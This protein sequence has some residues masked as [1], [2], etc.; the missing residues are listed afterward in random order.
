[1]DLLFHRIQ[2]GGFA[3]LH[4]PL[5]TALQVSLQIAQ[6]PPRLAQMSREPLELSFVQILIKGHHQGT[7]LAEDFLLGA[8]GFH[9]FQARLSQRPEL[10]A[11]N[12]QQLGM[13]RG[14]QRSHEM[15]GSVLQ[16]LKGLLAIVALVKDQGDVIAGFGQ[17]PVMGREF[18]GDGA[19]LGAVVDIAGVNLVEQ[20]DVE[21]GADQQAET[22]LAQIAAL[23]LI[24]PALRQF[25]RGADIDVGEEIGAVVDQGAEIQLKPLDE[26]LG[27]LFFAFED[28]IGGDQIHMVPEALGRQRGR[29]GGQQTSQDRLAVPVSKVHFAGGG[30]RTIDGSQEQ[31]LPEG[32]ALVA[33]GRKDGI[34][35]LDEIQSLRN[36]EKSGGISE[37]GDLGFE[38]LGRLLRPLGG[39]DEVVDF[40]EVGGRFWACR[41]RADNSGRSNRCG[42]R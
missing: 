25:G 37:S 13:L 31:V 26:A 5:P 12:G 24:M 40:A 14:D 33:F 36:V 42:R 23:L 21:I 34:E 16:R 38:G 10:F 29:I 18:F 4:L 8:I 28:V 19:E 35:Q 6:F 32:D 22:D 11:G 20:G 30:N 41:R 9:S 15:K 17:L 2:R 39:S 27:D 1:M 7:R 3:S